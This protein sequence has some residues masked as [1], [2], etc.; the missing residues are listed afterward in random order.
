M[1]FGEHLVGEQHPPYIIGEIGQNHNGD[2]YVATRLCA[3][4]VKAGMQAV[5][6]CVRDLEHELTDELRDQ[7][8]DSPNSF[9]QTYGEHREA[10][11]LSESDLKH[12]RDRIDANRPGWKLDIFA[13]VCHPSKVDMVARALRPPIWKVASRDLDNWPLLE[14]IRAYSEPV[15]LSTGMA[16]EAEI[17]E[18]V[19]FFPAGRVAVL[20][21][22][23][24]YPCSDPHL[25]RIQHLRRMY[26]GVPIGWSDHCEGI[27][28]ASHAVAGGAE[29]VE[30]HIT[31][32][33][34]MKGRDHAGA[35]DV[36]ELGPLVE[37]CHIAWAWRGHVGD[38]SDC[39]TSRL[40]RGLY[41]ACDIEAGE[42]ITS[43]QVEIVSPRQSGALRPRHIHHLI[44]QISVG[45][46]KAGTA[47][48]RQQFQPV[49]VVTAQ[50]TSL[51]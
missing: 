50:T 35:A 13:S 14:A 2:V 11:E 10:L 45:G 47:L 4:A 17:R 1:K 6:L 27:E 49:E 51:E 41:A 15:I 16:T 26:P 12:L 22:R 25:S 7:P 24:E 20:H 38:N 32:S 5:K 19:E 37:A 33:K 40:Q 44:G 8:Y 34:D 21:C 31:L 46:I 29:I 3:A 28:V 48:T 42:A 18:A 9:G 23:S 36:G 43:D 30:K 39:A